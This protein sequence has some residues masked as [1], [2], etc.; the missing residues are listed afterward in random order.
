[1]PCLGGAVAGSRC[2]GNRCSSRCNR[3]E[4]RGGGF[5]LQLECGGAGLGTGDAADDLQGLTTCAERPA[6]GADE[7]LE[8]VPVG[9]C[10]VAAQR[11]GRRAVPS[12]TL[13]P[14]GPPRGVPV[15]PGNGSTS[16]PRVAAPTVEAWTAART[17]EPRPATS[18]SRGGSG[19]PPRRPDCPPM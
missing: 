8:C 10:V 1:S 13:V 2:P 14:A 6:S 9:H 3:L 12:P 18:S 16:F 7:D 19:F 11:C 15:L 17:T 5:T 4:V